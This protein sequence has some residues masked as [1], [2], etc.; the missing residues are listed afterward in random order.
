MD[1]VGLVEVDLKADVEDLGMEVERNGRLVV[2]PKVT[3]VTVPLVGLKLVLVAPFTMESIRSWM[4]VDI[5]SVEGFLVVPIGSTVVLVASLLLPVDDVLLPVVPSVTLLSF[6]VIVFAF[7]VGLLPLPVGPI[8]SVV[9]SVL[10]LVN[11][12]AVN[13]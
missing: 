9:I 11:T 1:L 2:D 5:G 7:S 6:V 4:L 8:P 12:G 13:M 10:L 3:L